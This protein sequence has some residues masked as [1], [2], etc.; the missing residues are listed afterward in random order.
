MYCIYSIM[1]WLKAIIK[2]ERQYEE[3]HP[4]NSTKLHKHSGA[5]SCYWSAHP[6]NREYW[7]IFLKVPNRPCCWNT[8][9][10][11]KT[12]RRAEDKTQELYHREDDEHTWRRPGCDGLAAWWDA[13]TRTYRPCRKIWSYR[14]HY[15]RLEGSWWLLNG[16]AGWWTTQSYQ[17]RLHRIR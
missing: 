1:E 15:L 4:L 16:N 6:G 5:K 12:L 7:S 17:K 9:I 3:C 11:Q 2:K 14:V 13:S 8:F 10:C